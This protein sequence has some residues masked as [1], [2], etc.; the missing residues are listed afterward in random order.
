MPLKHPSLRHS[1]RGAEGFRFDATRLGKLTPWIGGGLLCAA[2]PA[3]AQYSL[4]MA[5]DFRTYSPQASQR[6]PI[7]QN[8]D[9]NLK[10][11]PTEWTFAAGLSVGWT[12]NAQMTS[13]GGS[14]S[15]IMTPTATANMVMPI[16]ERTSLT[17]GVTMGYSFYLD[18]AASNLS[19]FYV[20]PNT[21]L[22]YTMYVGD[23]QIAFYNSMA[24]SRFAFN[25]P[26]VGS[27]NA[28][29]R[30]FNNAFGCTASTMLYKTQLTGGFSQYNS[31]QL[32]GVGGVGD[33][34]SQ[35]VF[36]Q[37][38]Y[39]VLP[40]LMAGIN[41]GLT[42][43]H[44]GGGGQTLIDGGFQWN[45]GPNLNWTVTEL[46]NVN[47]SFGYTVYTQDY[48]F[49]IPS[50]ETGSMYWQ[51]GLTHN[52]SRLMTY[53]LS[54]GHTISPNYFSGPTDAY[55]ISLALNWKLIKDVSIST[56]FTYYNGVGLDQTT[57]SERF[58]TYATGIS[59]GYPFTQKLS[60][61]LNYYFNYRKQ[62]GA[63]G[64]YTVN[65]IT[66]GVSYRF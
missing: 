66:L 17:L 48:L 54:G 38:G 29:A 25:D 9:Y 64:D 14:G 63:V 30:T 11:G 41:G 62:A 33:T 31:W 55:N 40:E 8:R 4:Q 36:G 3:S 20:A 58:Q 42:W 56:P 35:N 37:V 61:S 50:T 28:D 1:T 46:L 24:V 51:L 12:S 21:R 18:D 53:T 47:G 22:A 57:A 10:L 34:G 16:A 27:N 6:A 7:A 52:L 19:G 23:V 13:S 44:Y 5:D 32:S 43:Q 15:F 59:F 45:V 65:G 2:L 26:T 60:G 49:N 39:Q